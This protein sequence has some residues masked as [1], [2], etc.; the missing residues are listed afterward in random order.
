MDDG[1]FQLTSNKVLNI[2]P[3]AVINGSRSPSAYPIVTQ[4]A[5]DEAYRAPQMNNRQYQALVSSYS[6]HNVSIVGG[7]SIEGNGWVCGLFFQPVL[8]TPITINALSW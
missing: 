7:G 5:L 2:S 6:A 1:A 3:D 8:P 4:L